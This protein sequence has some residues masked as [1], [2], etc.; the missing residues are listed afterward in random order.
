MYC[1]KC[2]ILFEGEHCPVCGSENVRPPLPDDLCLLTE[3]EFM[4]GEMLRD[5]LRQ[6]NIPVLTKNVLG[7]GLS[8][9]L[10]PMLERLRFYVPYSYLP[11]AQAIVEELFSAPREREQKED[12]TDRP[13]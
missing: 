7:A 6:N 5:V 3:K 12:Q 11:E 10:G 2:S 8:L 13:E 4:W 1:K 9:K